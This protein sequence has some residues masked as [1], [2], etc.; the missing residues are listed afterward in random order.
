M[1]R[2]TRTRVRA[3]FAY[4]SPSPESTSVVIATYATGNGTPRVPYWPYAF[5]NLTVRF[6]S[7]DDFPEAANQDAARDL[8]EALVAG[9]LRYPIAAE[10]PLSEIVRAHELVEDPGTAGRVLP[11][12]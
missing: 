6:L 2:R 11:K 12:M 3:R 4:A 5:K 10:L 9:D 7:N 1:R 8:T